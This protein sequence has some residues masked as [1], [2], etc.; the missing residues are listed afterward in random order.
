MFEQIGE[1]SSKNQYIGNTSTLSFELL[2]SLDGVLFSYN[3]VHLASCHGEV[4]TGVTMRHGYE[5]LD[6]RTTR[7]RVDAMII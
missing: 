4:P 6:E 1:P 5:K 2:A 3:Y 7:V